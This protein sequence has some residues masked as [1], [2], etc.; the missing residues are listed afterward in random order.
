LGSIRG[1][2]LRKEKLKT[3]KASVDHMDNSWEEIKNYV[4][5]N[6]IIERKK[7]N[8]EII[9]VSLDCYIN[10]IRA[11]GFIERIGRGKYKKII[12]IPNHITSVKIQKIAYDKSYSNYILRLL[13]KEKLKKINANVAGGA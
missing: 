3:I 6:D 4:N 13:R 10:Y 9:S 2:N 1:Y 7:I 5:S 11:A 8:K 12:N